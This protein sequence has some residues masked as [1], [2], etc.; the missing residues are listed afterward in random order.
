MTGQV[1][2]GDRAGGVLVTGRW[3]VRDKAGGV[4]VTGRWC[5]VTGHVIRQ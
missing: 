1:V 5:L 4:L 2:F 3:C